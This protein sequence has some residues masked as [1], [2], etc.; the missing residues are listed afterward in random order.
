[1]SEQKVMLRARGADAQ[2]SSDPASL[3]ATPIGEYLKRQRMLR[4]MSV[5]ELAAETR[6]PL[7]SLE[8][9]EAGYFDGVS[10]GF[11]RGFVRTVAQALGL[12]ADATVARM[13]DEPAASPWDRSTA[14]LWRK[15]ALA[16]VALVA[17]T[18]FS[19]WI[20]RAGWNLLVGGGASGS[21]EVVVW[22]DPVH[23]LAREHAEEQRARRAAE[24]AA[25]AEEADFGAHP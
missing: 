6:I 10:D 8:R 5:E 20:L 18:L 19:L 4:G 25:E 11:V 2:A 17:V 12:D 1:M 9:L 15:Q 21:R 7:R 3:A 24:A 23:S 13:L 16:V 14:G 22:R